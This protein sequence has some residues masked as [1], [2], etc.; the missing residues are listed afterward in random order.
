[1]D[2]AGEMARYFAF[3]LVAG[4]VYFLL[5]VSMLI[6]GFEATVLL[7]LAVVLTLLVTMAMWVVDE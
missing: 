5:R 1:M 2:F 3:G 6:R 4:A 7:V